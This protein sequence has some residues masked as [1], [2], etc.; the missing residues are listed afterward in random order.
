MHLTIPLHRNIKKSDI[1]EKITKKIEKEVVKKY[2]YPAG[3]PLSCDPC[4]DIYNFYA[5]CDKSPLLDDKEGT[6]EQCQ[7]TE[8]NVGVNIVSSTLGY[9]LH[10]HLHN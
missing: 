4:H 10:L 3:D 6:D 2:P 9:S 7:D 1:Q 8:A 5:Q